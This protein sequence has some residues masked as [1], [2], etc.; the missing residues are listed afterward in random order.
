MAAHRFLLL[1]QEYDPETAAAN[2]LEQVVAVDT[3]ARLVG[4]SRFTGGG[5][6]GVGRYLVGRNGLVGGQAESGSR[7]RRHWPPRTVRGSSAPHQGHFSTIFRLAPPAGDRLPP[8]RL[9][10][11]SSKLRPKL[12][13]RPFPL[14]ARGGEEVT[15]FIL[16]LRPARIRQGLCDF[17]TKHLPYL[18]RSR[19]IATLALS[20]LIPRFTAHC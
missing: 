13:T 16:D 17:G 8:H 20:T 6:L 2:L 1:S 14:K 19:C 4:A 7:Q 11:F 15:D 3:A 9:L 12:Q 10:S 18:R 5:S